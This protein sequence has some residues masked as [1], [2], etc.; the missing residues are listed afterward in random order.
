VARPLLAFVAFGTYIGAITAV[1]AGDSGPNIGAITIALLT[2][3]FFVSG[4]AAVFSTS[5]FR[6]SSAGRFV[7]ATF[8]GL[9]FLAFALYGVLSGFSG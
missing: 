8:V 6:E 1:L 9:V 5:A 4:T 7:T 2:L 3:V